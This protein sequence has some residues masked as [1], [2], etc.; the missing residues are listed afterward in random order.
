MDRPSDFTPVRVETLEEV[1][2]GLKESF[3][4]AAGER[5]TYVPCLN[6]SEESIHLLQ[7]LVLKELRGWIPE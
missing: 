5:F 4:D 7:E 3:L 1:A 2:I 6:S